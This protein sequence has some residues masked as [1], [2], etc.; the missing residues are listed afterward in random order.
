M[1]HFLLHSFG[2]N[3]FIWPLCERLGHEIYLCAKRKVVHMLGEQ[4]TCYCLQ[5]FSFSF[6]FFFEF[7]NF[8]LFIFLYS[9]FVLVIHFIHIS[10]YTSIPISQF[11]TPPPHRAFY[12]LRVS[13][14]AMWTSE[15]LSRRKEGKPTTEKI[16]K[17]QRKTKILFWLHLCLALVGSIIFS[18]Q[19]HSW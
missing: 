11:I 10:V 3:P 15:N 12:F 17:G 7:L 8:I 4:Q 9:R 19:R 2:Q 6:F 14:W 1:N 18:C 16:V 5:S 13:Q